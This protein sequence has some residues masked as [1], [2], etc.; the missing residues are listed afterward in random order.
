[1]LLREVAHETAR[2]NML[3]LVRYRCPLYINS[4]NVIDPSAGKTKPVIPDARG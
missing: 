2:N 3:V 4:A 1:M